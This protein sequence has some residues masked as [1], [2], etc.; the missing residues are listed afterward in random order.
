MHL[1]IHSSDRLLQVASG[2]VK[3]F[4]WNVACKVPENTPLFHYRGNKCL[5][6][7]IADSCKCKCR[8][9][10]LIDKFMN[11]KVNVCIYI[12]AYICIT[13]VSI[14]TYIYTFVQVYVSYGYM[15]VEAGS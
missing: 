5:S 9:K 2:E 11:E 6:R 13:G 4:L 1:Y 15:T 14:C 12:H 3:F 8:H 10:N 7:L